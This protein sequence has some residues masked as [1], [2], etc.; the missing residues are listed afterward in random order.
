MRRISAWLVLLMTAAGAQGQ[1][2]S[3]PFSA[4]STL[5]L[6]SGYGS[7][8]DLFALL[9]GACY[10]DRGSVGLPALGALFA[11]PPNRLNVIYDGFRLDDPLTGL[12]DLN[13]IP[14]ESMASQVLFADPLTR[15]FPA[16]PASQTLEVTGRDLTADT[17]RTQVAYRSGGNGYDDID[18]RAGLRYSQRLWINGGGVLKNYAGATA[19]L[20]KYHAQK[21]NLALTR[22]FGSHWRARY[23]LLY[24]ISDLNLPLPEAPPAAPGLRQPHQKLSRYDHGLEIDYAGSWRTLVQLTDQH[25]ERYG[26]RHSLWDETTDV[27]RFDL[28]STW[29]WR[30]GSLSGTTGGTFRSTGLKSPAWGDHGRSLCSGW[31][32]LIL[33]PAPRLMAFTQLRLEKEE[34]MGIALLP[35]LQLRYDLGPSPQT[36]ARPDSTATGDAGP[37]LD[38]ALSSTASSP[39]RWQSLLWYERSRREASLAER[40]ETGPFALGDPELQAESGDHLGLGLSGH[41]PAWK[42]LLFLS[43]SRTREELMLVQEAPQT[44]ALYR[45]QP[46]QLRFSID[47]AG[48]WRLSSWFTLAGKAKQ[49]LFEEQAPLNQSATCAAGWL[50]VR[51]IFFHKDL[52]VRLRLGSFFWGEREGPLPWYV[53]ASKES[54]PLAA[55]AVPW[56]DLSVVIRDA[57]LFFALQNPLDIDYEVVRGYPQPRRLIRWGFV[58]NFYD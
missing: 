1:T 34:G 47:L 30:R 3:A 32:S 46:G 13:L 21:I 44:A 5:R 8:G 23:R 12:S 42:L 22:T 56:L 15:P 48:E 4:D 2:M 17:L 31:G 57:T 58:W 53:D 37:P 39:A 54:E 41:A 33:H 29:L 36:S 35:Q 45:N 28:T 26:Y 19:Q 50:G 51:H 55:A 7:A 9:P 25:R 43:A 10:Q 11:A 16:W 6:G 40:Y 18:V 38:S 52:D 27:L 20:E 49:M 14:V 24:N